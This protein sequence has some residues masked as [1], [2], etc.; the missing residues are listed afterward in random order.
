MVIAALATALIV[1]TVFLGIRLGVQT[2]QQF[3]EINSSW[4][5][6]SGG[7]ERKGILISTLRDHLGY[8]G[9][10]HNFKNYVLRKDPAY[11]AE[12][13]IQIEQFNTVIAAFKALDLKPEEKAALA[14]ILGTIRAYEANLRI[15]EKAARE[16]W[17]VTRT[18]RLVRIDDTAAIGALGTLEDIWR[19]IQAA[20]TRRI[21]Q[22]VR[23][24]QNLILIGFFSLAA[25]T[26]AAAIIGALIY[27]LIQSLR[28]AIAQLKQELTER[29]RLQRS[30]SRLAT[31]VEQSPATILITDTEARI[32]YVNAKFEDLTGWERDEVIG[33]TPAFLQSGKTTGATYDLIRRQL[34]AGQSWNG[35]FLNRKKDGG[36]YWAD[37][38][39]LP[40]VGPDGTVSN[41]IATGEDVTEKRHAREQVA[42][43]QKLEV[44][45]QLSGGIAHDF[46]NILTTIV[47]AA[48]L[49]AMD[50]EPGSDLAGEIE[51]ID[52]AAQ[53]AKS[54]VRE[55]L[56][57]ARREPGQPQT[58]DLAAIVAEVTRLLRASIPPTIELDC[59][60]CG[61][62]LVLADPTHLHQILMN[63]C[64]NA[65][66][67][68]GGEEG[69]I[70]VRF[71]PGP[72]PEAMSARDDGWIYLEVEDNGPGMSAET[73]K[74]LFEPFFTTKPLGK[75]AGLG[76]AVVQGLVDEIGGRITVDSTPG[77]GT[78]FL[79]VL[80]GSSGE[81]LNE[82]RAAAE[83]PRGR[84]T[85]LLVDD[86]VEI[87]GTLRRFLL[88]L[89]YR[90]EAFSSP[91][92]ALERFRKAPGRFDIVLSDLLMP[93]ISGE[94]LA[95]SV[96]K[97]RPGLPVVFVTGYKPGKISVPGP[98]PQVL[99]KPVDPARLAI[100]IRRVL[101][102]RATDSTAV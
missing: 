67:A 89:G 84:E 42:R 54:L 55:L 61:A 95:A 11:L 63:L 3:R 50:A 15:A 80:P 52:I 2:R 79:V 44:V 31:A 100:T 71:R 90:V 53:R 82:T 56:T 20:S 75:G 34:Q 77:E 32:Q 74:R 85:V 65:A 40:L 99:D 36:E 86:D 37:T 25:L 98:Q 28:D 41:Y 18:D 16:G 73:C 69:R 60:D 27:V 4:T 101:D 22:S 10:I 12:T 35:V 1:V 51:Q 58:V 70:V 87:S 5:D 62:T 83:L 29:R 45:G 17:T 78:R 72:P 26:L 38:T 23:E 9:I 24:G 7:A 49:A 13:R 39:I 57:F 91:V 48:H 76:L 88:R 43:A 64:R 47:G 14:T 102:H 19:D 68:I 66:E 46:N 94:K 96:R 93:D 59:E 81:A 33:Q 21:V 30:E 97:L 8:G 6:Y 92:V